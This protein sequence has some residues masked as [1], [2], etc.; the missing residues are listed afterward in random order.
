MNSQTYVKNCTSK[1]I[2]ISVF[3]ENVVMWFRHVLELEVTSVGS[4]I[5]VIAH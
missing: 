4:D 1:L 3:S 2:Y 5:V